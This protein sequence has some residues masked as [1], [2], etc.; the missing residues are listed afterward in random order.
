MKTTHRLAALKRIDPK[1]IIGEKFLSVSGNALTPTG[2][3]PALRLAID[4]Y[5]K[6]CDIHLRP[7]YEVDNLSGAMSLITS[8]DSVALLPVYAKSLF[9]GLV[10]S[11]PLKGEVPTIDLCFGFKKGNNSPILKLLLSRLDELIARVS[12]KLRQ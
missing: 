4:A 6:K 5:L 2:A 11:R 7:S 1:E 8:T 9:S 10:T 12:S 3:A